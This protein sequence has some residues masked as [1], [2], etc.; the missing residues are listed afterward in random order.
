MSWLSKITGVNIN[1]RKL[2]PSVVATYAAER[3]WA[4]LLG[5]LNDQELRELSQALDNA[6]MERKK[7]AGYNG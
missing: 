1:V 4:K 6:W 5:Q 3:A 7:K 2:V